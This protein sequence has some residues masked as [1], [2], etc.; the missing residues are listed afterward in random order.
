MVLSLINP[1]TFFVIES[2]FVPCKLVRVVYVA[3]IMTESSYYTRMK[4]PRQLE[5]LKLTGKSQMRISEKKR[6]QLEKHFGHSIDPKADKDREQIAE[7]LIEEY[8]QS[9]G[10]VADTADRDRQQVVVHS[11]VL[12]P[13]RTARLQVP[14]D[15]SR[16]EADRLIKFIEIL[17]AE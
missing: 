1:I 10:L 7:R 15:L 2:V 14:A 5:Y 11:F 13:G 4:G 16:Q 17:P 6:R 8:S 3:Q 9:H 12:R